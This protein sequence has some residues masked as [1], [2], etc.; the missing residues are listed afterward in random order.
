[1]S[2]PPRGPG[3]A[4]ARSPSPRIGRASAGLATRQPPSEQQGGKGDGPAAMRPSFSAAAGR[5][6]SCRPGRVTSAG[7]MPAG[8]C[9][10]LDG[11]ADTK[12]SRRPT[13]GTSCAG[14]LVRYPRIGVD[15]LD[16][17]P[18]VKPA[19]H[20]VRRS[21]RYAVPIPSCGGGPCLQPARLADRTHRTDDCT[22]LP[23]A[24][25]DAHADTEG[26]WP[27]RPRLRAGWACWVQAV[28][29]RGEDHHRPDARSPGLDLEAIETPPPDARNMAME[30]GSILGK[31]KMPGGLFC[32]AAS[33]PSTIC[34]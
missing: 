2:G 13:F 19:M 23:T 22:T 15:L 9:C 10:L 24:S 31:K 12:L 20:D 25:D 14:D 7:S 3:R 28:E 17:G 30:T 4:V 16:E 33:K 5:R 32:R 29:R 18:V 27:W 6:S 21:G 34:S 8:R 26:P 1:M 11:V